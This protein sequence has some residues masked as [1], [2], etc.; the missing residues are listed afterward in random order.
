MYK[1]LLIIN[2]KSRSGQ[3]ARDEVTKELDA[4]G[5]T[6]LNQGD[7]EPDQ[8]PNEIILKYQREADLVIVGGGDGSV[9][10]VLPALKETGL[11][12]LVIPL[13]TANNLARTY[14]LPTKIQESVEL[15]R[16]KKLI[17][18][19]LGKVNDVLFVNVAGLGLST[20]INKNVS[21]SLKRHLGVVA[22]ILTAF[23]MIYRMNPFRARIWVDGKEP[24][25]SKSWQ[26][27]VCNGKYYGAGMAIKH[28]ATLED[29][30][31]HCLTTEVKKWWH[32]FALIPALMTGRYKKEHDLTLVSGKD[33]RI[34]TKRMFAIDV[35]GDI[36]THTP[37]VFTVLPKCLT[38]IVPEES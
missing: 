1:V 14:N 35:D 10:Q 28:N 21:S 37:A 7:H 34:E 32:G 20:E 9:N 24:I 19:D 12:L 2:P 18:V 5:M 26:I 23:K 4:A 30:R 13:G 22:F 17:S 8:D 33:I 3:I 29:Q 11:P 31:L 38:L 15:L 16:T 25:H 36:K 27:S 6:I